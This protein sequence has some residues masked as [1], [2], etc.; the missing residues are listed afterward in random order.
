MGRKIRPRQG[1]EK[2]G[3]EA[4]AFGVTSIQDIQHPDKEFGAPN[5]PDELEV[6]DGVMRDQCS[7]GIVLVVL[8][9]H[10][11]D[12]APHFPAG[13]RGECQRVE[14][15]HADNYEIKTGSLRDTAE[16]LRVKKI[17]T[18]YISMALVV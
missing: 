8:V 14:Q 16:Q 1:P 15:Y 9:T 10:V 5:V 11:T 13:R 7:L 4:C 12:P 3:V 6:I 18:D 2:P 17:D